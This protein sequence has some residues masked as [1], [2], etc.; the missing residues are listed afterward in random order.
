[1]N[2]TFSI[3]TAKPQFP[4]DPKLN[5]Q[6]KSPTQIPKV[7]LLQLSVV[8][9]SLTDTILISAL[10]NQKQQNSNNDSISCSLRHNK[11][12]QIK[13]PKQMT[14]ARSPDKT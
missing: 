12:K 14:R 9:F 5:C 7:F 1:M 11:Q 13:K 8:E 4:K 3:K 6:A 10:I 2:E